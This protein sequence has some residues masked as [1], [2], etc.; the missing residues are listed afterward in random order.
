VRKALGGLYVGTSKDIYLLEGTGGELPDGTIDFTLRPLN[1]DH[2][3]ISEAVA[4][5]GNLMVYLADDGW[6]AMGGAGSTLLSGL[7]SIL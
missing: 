1:I 7:T 5:E 2:P 6:R 4:Q 3:P